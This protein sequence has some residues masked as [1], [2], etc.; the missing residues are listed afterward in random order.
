MPVTVPT[1][2]ATRVIRV[3]PRRTISHVVGHLCDAKLPPVVSRTAIRVYSKL[4]AIDM[5]DV[6]PL[7]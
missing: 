6:L 1:Y 4:Y 5:A 3:L 2:I 7:D